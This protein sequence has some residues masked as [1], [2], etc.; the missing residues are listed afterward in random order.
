MTISAQ[1][2]KQVKGMGFLHNRGTKDEFSGRII[3]ENGVI[4]AKQL[5][6]VSEAAAKFGNGKVSFSTRLTIEIPGIKFGDIEAFQDYIAQV[7]LVTGGTGTRVRPVVSCKGTTCVFG[8]YDTQALGKEIHK[9]FYNDYYDVALPHKFKIANGGCPNNCVKPEL[10]DLGIVGQLVPVI[11]LEKCKSCKVCGPE[12]VCPMDASS[13]PNGKIAID[14]EKCNNCGRCIPRCPFHA[15]V[16]YET[17]YS[18]YVGGRWG[19]KTRIGTPLSRLFNEGELMDLIEKALL[20]FKRDGIKGE[21]FG[22]TVDRMG[23]EKVEELL[24][25]NELLDQKRQILAG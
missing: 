16:G 23:L 18:V 9:R 2:I 3:T 24:C 6:N 20:L 10:N 22:Q 8:L 15:V 1:D 25:S 13:R 4:T 5:Q 14:R 17:Q 11:E 7:N 19:K 12:E 21:R